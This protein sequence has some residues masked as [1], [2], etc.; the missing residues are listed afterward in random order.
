MFQ[1]CNKDNSA[2]RVK[3]PVANI[4]D[5]GG[6]FNAGP[7]GATA[8][9]ISQGLLAY[10]PMAG[11]A[12][13]ISGNGFDGAAHAIQ[14][15][16]DRMQH[17]KGAYRFLGDGE[18]YI[19]V[20]P[21]VPLQLAST[22]FTINAWVNVVRYND[23]S[24]STLLYNNN[25]A[26]WAFFLTGSDWGTQGVMT[27]TGST[28]A[29]GTS[30]VGIANWHMITLTYNVTAQELSTYIDGVLDSKS[31]NTAGPTSTW[32]ARLYIGNNNP[33]VKGKA[34]A[35][36][37]LMGDMRV[38]NRVINGDE[39]QYLYTVPTA[40]TDSLAAYW[41]LTRYAFNDLSG[42]GN[43]LQRTDMTPSMDRLGNK[44]GSFNFNG[45]TS[46]AVATSSTPVNL[47]G[48]D[49]TLNAWVKLSAYGTHSS[50]INS[51]SSSGVGVDLSV[52]DQGQ[53][54]CW[55]SGG[56]T[57][58]QRKLSLQKWYMVSAVYSMS[59]NTVKIYVNGNLNATGTN[60]GAI[61]ANSPIYL[62]NA[63]GDAGNPGGP[64]NGHLNDVRIFN[65]QLSSIEVQQL[66]KALN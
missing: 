45:T 7:N 54:N 22:D 24:R 29:Q 26:G 30:P 21:T 49:F 38:Y 62:G 17:K 14:N 57:T 27:M 18:G 31:E 8:N 25:P 6:D 40:P 13:D 15:V 2:S 60:A 65:R 66:V 19:A 44:V 53:V 41:P 46:K 36:T 63:S 43:N 16:M 51:V 59:N 58:T 1:S 52:N 50:I 3:A 56:S 61:T 23:G 37:G 4:T 28:F 35:F 20:E 32:A 48:A 64:L 39:L 42:N 55:V 11:Y 12:N 34:V 5:S 9:S 33:S 10:W 47:Q